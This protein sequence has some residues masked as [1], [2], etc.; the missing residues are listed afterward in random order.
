MT[1]FDKQCAIAVEKKR[2]RQAA[3]AAAAESL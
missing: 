2:E 3:K 1:Q